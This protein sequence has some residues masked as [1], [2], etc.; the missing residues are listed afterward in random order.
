MDSSKGGHEVQAPLCCS[1]SFQSEAGLSLSA[2][3][4]ANRSIDLLPEAVTPTGV[5]GFHKTISF[6]SFLCVHIRNR[7]R[8]QIF[9]VSTKGLWGMR[10]KGSKVKGKC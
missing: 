3:F 7:A 4:T 5:N 10:S 9:S 8:V 1:D 2:D 6:S